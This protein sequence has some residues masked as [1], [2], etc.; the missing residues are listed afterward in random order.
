[1]KGLKGSMIAWGVVGL[2][3]GL[4][5]IVFPSQLLAAFG[6]SLV[7]SYVQYI[8]VL[9]GNVS[10]AS[11]IFVI[12]AAGD[13]LRH[14]LLLQFAMTWS[15]L[16]LIAS[17]VFILRGNLTFIQAG[18]GVIPNLILLAAFLIFYPWHKPTAMDNR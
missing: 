18:A 5:F 16:D 12:L 8:L 4:V 3:F 6:V 15:L 2:L 13:P 10:I 1:M 9:L 14:I 7:P 11:G 17:L